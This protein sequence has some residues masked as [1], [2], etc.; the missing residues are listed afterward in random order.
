MM[1][2]HAPKMAVIVEYSVGMSGQTMHP[3]F[4]FFVPF[5]DR[6][7]YSASSRLVPDFPRTEHWLRKLKNGD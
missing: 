3:R 6:A 5:F 4:F 1:W 2:D 7:V